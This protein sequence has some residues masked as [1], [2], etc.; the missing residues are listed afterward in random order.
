MTPIQKLQDEIVRERIIKGMPESQ[1]M[2][3]YAKENAEEIRIRR[4]K[5]REMK[6]AEYRERWIKNYKTQV[7]R[8][9]EKVSARK[10]LQAAVK[11][12][13]VVR[14]RCSYEIHGCDGRIEGHH[15]D[16]TKALE[17]KWLCAKHHRQ[18]EKGLLS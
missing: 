1:Y 8:H 9:P 3:K 12:G 16:Y 2:K 15:H 10:K 6:R 18:Y 4:A 17:V 7:A 11:N 14:G 13:S 5:E